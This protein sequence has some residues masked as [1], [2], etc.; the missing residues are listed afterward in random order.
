MRKR[1]EEKKRAYTALQS[2]EKEHLL[3]S[4]PVFAEEREIRVVDD[5]V[6]VAVFVR[7]HF[8]PDRKALLIY[9]YYCYLFI[10]I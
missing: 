10:I 8:G 2:L 3:R 9:F 7:H 5:S 6:V 4:G 1:R